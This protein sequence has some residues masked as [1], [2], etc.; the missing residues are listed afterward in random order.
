MPTKKIEINCFFFTKLWTFK[1]YKHIK[2][3]PTMNVLLA[4]PVNIICL[5]KNRNLETLPKKKFCIL[6]MWKRGHLPYFRNNIKVKHAWKS[7]YFPYS[8]HKTTKEMWIV[9]NPSSL[10]F[11]QQENEEKIKWISLNK[12]W[13]L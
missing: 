3:L 7:L 5:L 12:G 11:T 8:P 4:L 1:I 6:Y 9:E 10:M 2:T 13:K